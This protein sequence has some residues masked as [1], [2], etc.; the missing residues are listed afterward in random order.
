MLMFKFYTRINNYKRYTRYTIGV[1]NNHKRYYNN[2]V[3][4]S[5]NFNFS[6]S[7]YSYH[8]W[9]NTFSK[10]I[11]AITYIIDTIRKHFPHWFTFNEITTLICLQPWISTSRVKC[12]NNNQ[13]Y[14]NKR[15]RY[16]NPQRYSSI[17]Y[18]PLPN[19]LFI[20]T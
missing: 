6:I 2:K 7:F 8:T 3:I 12:N 15:N 5:I 11:K 4:T 10:L 17:Q 20:L 18:I 14:I 16:P 19:P 1:R 13:R 9:F